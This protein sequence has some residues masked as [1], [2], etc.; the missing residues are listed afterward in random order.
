[1]KTLGLRLRWENT[2][3]GTKQGLYQLFQ[4]VVL[5][6]EKQDEIVRKINELEKH[7]AK[8]DV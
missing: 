2:I 3:G 1:M 8:E 6:A 5:I 7:Q 4:A